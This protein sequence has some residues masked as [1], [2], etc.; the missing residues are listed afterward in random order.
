MDEEEE[1]KA[2]E[3]GVLEG[4]FGCGNDLDTRRYENEYLNRG[5]E[6][7][8][9]GENA[10]LERDA[11]TILH[12]WRASIDSRMEFMKKYP[13]LSRCGPSFHL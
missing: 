5:W 9:E 11:Y 7:T 4:A 1:E 2:S 8:R 3:N 10:V 6:E 13:L 12:V